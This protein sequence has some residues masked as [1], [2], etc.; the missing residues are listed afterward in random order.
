MPSAKPK[1][2]T[3][4][5]KNAFIAA[6]L[7]LSFLYQKPIKNDLVYISDKDKWIEIEEFISEKG[8]EPSNCEW[9]VHNGEPIKFYYNG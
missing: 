4:L 8:H 5:T 1:S 3:L 2:P 7:A 9:M 6:E